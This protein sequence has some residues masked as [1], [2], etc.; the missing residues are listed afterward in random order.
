MG[1]SCPVERPAD[2]PSDGWYLPLPPDDCRERD[3]KGLVKD[4]YLYR[5]YVYKGTF[6]PNGVYIS[7]I[8]GYKTDR[9][10]GPRASIIR[11]RSMPDG[12]QLYDYLDRLLCG[13]W[14]SDLPSGERYD[15]W[16]ESLKG[17]R[18]RWLTQGRMEFNPPT[19]NSDNNRSKGPIWRWGFVFVAPHTG[20]VMEAA[21]FA[22][23]FSVPAHRL[24]GKRTTPPY[25]KAY[26]GDLG[27]PSR[28]DGSP[29]GGISVCDG[30]HGRDF[31]KDLS[32][33]FGRGTNTT[34]LRSDRS[35]SFQRI[36]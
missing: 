29:I 10:H 36:G 24:I 26:L 31:A 5:T 35:I 16:D 9:S 28:A 2:V 33:R 34:N 14:L 18:G 23:A 19:F 1:L 20:E 12:Q 4:N 17:Q 32:A 21:N 25:L 6:Y 3:S 27:L 22:R 30:A 7:D 8:R 11:N 15:W 13:W